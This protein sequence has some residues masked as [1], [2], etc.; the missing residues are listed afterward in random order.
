MRHLDRHGLALLVE[1]AAL[2]DASDEARAARSAEVEEWLTVAY[3]RASEA[4]RVAFVGL[5]KAGGGEWPWAAVT[6][7]QVELSELQDELA[8]AIDRA[9]P[10][11]VLLVLASTNEPEFTDPDNWLGDGDEWI[12]LRDAL[13]SWAPETIES[14]MST[15]TWSPPIIKVD[16]SDPPKSEP[17][18]GS[19][20]EG[21]EPGQTPG[22]AVPPS[23]GP[24][25][26]PAPAPTLAPSVW[27]SWQLW[28]AVGVAAAATYG[29]TRM[30][31]G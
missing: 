2:I 18:S 9:P 29:L 1:Y 7:I 30:R 10:A 3:D 16:A 11:L 15:G 27:K 8:R 22:G 4:G 28:A 17:G 21:V 20:G 26:A 5:V 12:P 31:R 13:L 14:Y 6:P 23:Q 19:P 24:A 25:P